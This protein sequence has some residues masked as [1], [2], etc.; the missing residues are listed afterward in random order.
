M[1]F[2]KIQQP[3]RT[4]NVFFIFLY[5]VKGNLDTGPARYSNPYANSKGCVCFWKRFLYR[6]YFSVWLHSVVTTTQYL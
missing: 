5:Q 1:G 3:S 2:A 4:R 6:G